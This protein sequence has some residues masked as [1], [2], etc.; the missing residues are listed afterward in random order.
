[1]IQRVFIGRVVFAIVQK[2]DGP[3][4]VRCR[5]DRI[6]HRGSGLRCL[7]E[8]LDE[9]GT[10]FDFHTRYDYELYRSLAD[11]EACLD[12]ENTQS[13]GEISQCK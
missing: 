8:E 9:F 10:T 2:Q 13:K 7:V 6:K 12:N 1:M 4:A 5:I 11:A 3:H